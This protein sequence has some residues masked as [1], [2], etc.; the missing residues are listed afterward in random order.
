M[1]EVQEDYNFKPLWRLLIPVGL[2]GIFTLVPGPYP[3]TS[4][5]DELVRAHDNKPGLSIQD[6]RTLSEYS[7]IDSTKLEADY[8]LDGKLTYS[9]YPTKKLRAAYKKYTE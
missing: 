5:L 8:H 2:V 9:D 3:N 7:G 1:D 6:V 4:K